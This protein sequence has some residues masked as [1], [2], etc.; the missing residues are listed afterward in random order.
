MKSAFLIHESLRNGY[1]HLVSH[2]GPWLRRVLAFR[3]W[4]VLDIPGFYTSLGV[5]QVLGM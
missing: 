2:V 1:D 5:D 3:D 4:G